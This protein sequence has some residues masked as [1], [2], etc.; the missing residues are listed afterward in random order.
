MTDPANIAVLAAVAR[1]G[2]GAA[3]GVRP[4]T[5]AVSWCTDR[6][7]DHPERNVMVRKNGM[8]VF[9]RRPKEKASAGICNILAPLFRDPEGRFN[10]PLLFVFVVVNGL[11]LFNAV[12]HDPTIQYDGAA[13]LAYVATLAGLRLPTANQSYEFFSAPLPYVLPAVAKAAGLSLWWAAKGG[14]LVNVVLSLGITGGLIALCRSA[15]GPSDRQTAAIA[16]M[17]LG[18]LPVYYKTMAF[19]RGEPYVAFL[20][21]V[22]IAATAHAVTRGRRSLADVVV[23][24]LCWGFLVL[25]RQWG[26]LTAIGLIMAVWLTVLRER[27]RHAIAIGSSGPLVALLVG[28]WFYGWLWVSQGSPLAFNQPASPQWALRNEPTDFYAGTGNGRLF[29]DPI[30][31]S[32]PNQLIPIFYAETWGDYWG[33]FSI[34]GKEPETGT[35]VV[36]PA[37]QDATAKIPL[38]IETNRFTL[39]KYL[40]HVNLVGLVPTALALVAFGA[41]AVKVP[42]FLRRRAPVTPA[43]IIQ[44]MAVLVIGVSTLGYLWFLIRFPSPGKGDTIKPTY[45]VH[46]FPPLALLAA[47]FV[48]RLRVPLKVW[49]ITWALLMMH[50]SLAITTHFM[51]LP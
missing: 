27:N 41:A 9:D 1:P 47:D 22:G 4:Y 36:G 5:F 10:H 13:H 17:C 26:A 14:Q 39:N 16:L 49:V 3:N 46:I 12:C 38:T 2:S 24:G 7:V 15:R 28:G 35:Y 21:V 37:F 31:P 32:F 45:L 30:R 42:A 48:R 51:N 20:T 40:G 8:P 11:V 34:Y 33:V 43:E 29:T 19:V 6:E 25:A 44:M 18:A 50:N 23:P